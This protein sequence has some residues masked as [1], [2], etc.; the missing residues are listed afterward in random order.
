[1]EI[2]IQQQ[3]F[4]LLPQ[5]AIFWNEEKILIL[6]DLHLGKGMHFRKEGIAVPKALLH[7]DL[8][9]LGSL[10]DAF[11]P[12][13]IIIVGDMFHSVANHEVDL[14]E[15][16]RSSFNKLPIHLV[17]GNHDILSDSHYRDLQIEIHD[18]LLLH[19]FLFVHDERPCEH[20]CFS[21][22]LH[23]GVAI[24]GKGK[25][26][27]RLPCFHFGR[28]KVILPAFGKFTGLATISPQS[29]DRVF[30]IAGN[31]VVEIR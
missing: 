14:F 4:R 8:S 5:K 29:G 22:H 12:Q 6:S 23:P 7:D 20:F 11:Q 13:Q 2:E 3:H 10:I 30:A 18:S 15:I 16:W 27:L 31:D 9:R 28:N 1:M 26:S 17:K 25:Q 21:G 24:H 19:T